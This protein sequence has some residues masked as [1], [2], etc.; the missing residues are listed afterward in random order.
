MRGEEEIEQKKYGQVDES[1]DVR[2]SW[3]KTS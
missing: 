3:V 2:K 1:D